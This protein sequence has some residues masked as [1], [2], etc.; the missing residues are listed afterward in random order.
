MIIHSAKYYNGCTSLEKCPQSE[1]PEFAFIGRSNVGK[2]SL[3][4]L[5]TQNGKLAMTSHQPGKTVLINHYIINDKWFLVDL[6]GYGFARRSKTEKERFAR[7]IYSYIDGRRTLHNLFV[8]I[9]SNIP[10]QK[11]DLEF[12]QWLGEH[13]VPFNII[14]TKADKQSHSAALRNIETF[15]KTLLETWEELPQHFITSAKKK[16]GREEVLDYIDHLLKTTWPCD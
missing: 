6:P 2:S 4:N 16:T 13:G 11:I 9:D 15:N 10:P 7:M 8:L 5:L 1:L 12:I 3:I 14:F